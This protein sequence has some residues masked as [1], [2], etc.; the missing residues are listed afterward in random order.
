MLASDFK[1]KYV[2]TIHQVLREKLEFRSCEAGISF[3]LCD[4][5]K[6]FLFLC[7]DATGIPVTKESRQSKCI[8]L[9][10]GTVDVPGVSG[11]LR[12]EAY[13]LQVDQKKEVVLLKGESKTGVFYGIQTLLSL[14]DDTL[15][16]LPVA[17]I[18]DAPR[19]ILSELMLIVELQDENMEIVVS[20]HMTADV[21]LRQP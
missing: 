10:V 6:I 19:Y 21:S 15:S 5:F 7:L 14:G 4:T 12:Q 17:H 11:P 2:Q 9:T 16:H 8:V 1:L 18:T 3:F 13:S 20:A